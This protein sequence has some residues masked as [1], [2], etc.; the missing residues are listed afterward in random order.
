MEIL[1]IGNVNLLYLSDG[2]DLIGGSPVNVY[3]RYWFVL[4]NFLASLPDMTWGSIRKYALA[5]RER[6]DANEMGFVDILCNIEERYHRKEAVDVHMSQTNASS[7]LFL[8]VEGEGEVYLEYGGLSRVVNFPLGGS[9]NRLKMKLSGY[10]TRSSRRYSREHSTESPVNFSG[11]GYEIQSWDHRPNYK[12]MTLKKQVTKTYFGLEL[13][14]NSQIPWS[15]MHHVMTEVEPKQ[16]AFMF[17]KSDSSIEGKFDNCY[18]M[19]THPMSPRR[20]RVEFKTF[21]NKLEGLLTDKNLKMS[22]VFD[23][24]TKSTGIHVHVSQEAFIGATRRYQGSHRKKFLMFWNL[25][26]KTN[27]NFTSKLA[28]RDIRF[29]TYVKPSESYNGR[30][31]AWCLSTRGRPNDRYSACGDTGDTLEVRAYRGQPTWDAVKHAIEATE[32]ALRFTEVAPLSVFNRG[33]PQAFDKWLGKQNR[34]SYRTLK[35]NL[36]CV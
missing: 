30:T 24:D 4:P 23:V 2:S 5:N 1:K 29:N 15:D 6:L 26:S 14:V 12:F 21:F 17:S 10:E 32:A 7:F 36:K 3:E 18:E 19:V 33:L 35:E 16:E 28:R 27:V 31:V 34:N 22:D 8:P 11:G 9:G 25:N 13:E 20:M